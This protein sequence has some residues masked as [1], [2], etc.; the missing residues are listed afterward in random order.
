MSA[1]SQTSLKTRDADILSDTSLL[2]ERG[3]HDMDV[4]WLITNANM[5][6]HKTVVGRTYF[7]P[8]SKHDVHRH[9]HAEE[10]EFVLSGQGVKIVGEQ[11]FVMEAGDVCFCPQNVYHGL[12]NDSDEPLV[13]IWGYCGAG[14]LEE[15]GYQIPGDEDGADNP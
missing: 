9:P 5:G 2:P 8:G 4:K 15:A 6:S 13:T 1:E 10:W 14:S 7:P 11:E 12:R 3:W